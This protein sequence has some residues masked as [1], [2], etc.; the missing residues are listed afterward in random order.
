MLKHFS[1]AKT[2]YMMNYS[3]CSLIDDHGHFILHTGTNDLK[4]EE[5]SECIAQSLI[6]LAVF[7]KYE[8]C[9]VSPI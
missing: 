1:G 4:L 8:K 5:T 3:K 6:D 9:D 7:L 2:E